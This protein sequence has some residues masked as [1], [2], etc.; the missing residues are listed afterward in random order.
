LIGK[1]PLWENTYSR[2]LAQGRNNDP[3]KNNDPKQN[4]NSVERKK[5]VSHSIL[6]LY[7]FQEIPKLIGG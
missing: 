1:T 4:K 2:K 6:I 7:I 5:S 3:D